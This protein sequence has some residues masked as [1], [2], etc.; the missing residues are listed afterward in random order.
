[1]QPYTPSPRRNRST[2][3]AGDL[4]GMLSVATFFE[5]YDN[6]V[7]ALVLPLVLADLGG[8]EAEAGRH[9]GRSSGSARCWGS[10]WRRRPTG[11]AAAGCC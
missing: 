2:G 6:F 1:M 5:G 7:L 8:S 9:P 3:T 4:L 11:S 10:C